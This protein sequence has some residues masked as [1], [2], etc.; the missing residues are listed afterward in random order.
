[1]SYT[2]L[3]THVVF[4]TKDR[5]PFLKDAA[6]RSDLHA[7]LGG[8]VRNLKG[9]AYAIGGVE[10]HVHLLISL[11]AT[12]ATAD[13]LRTIK[14][15]SSSWAKSHVN[16]FAWQQ[17][18]GAFSVSQSGVPRVVRYIQGQEAHHRKQTFEEELRELLEKHGIDYDPRYLWT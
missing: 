12:I 17:K 5:R 13:A 15:N 14:T 2:C 8:I 9:R 6:L 7:Y 11:P 18:Y 1:V 3:L 16:G 10:D 4:S